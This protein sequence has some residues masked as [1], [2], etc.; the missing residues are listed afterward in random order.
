MVIRRSGY[1]VAGTS[2]SG[3]QVMRKD[4][5]KMINEQWPI[6]SLTYCQFCV[7]N[8]AICID[9]FLMS[10]FYDILHPDFLVL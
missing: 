1:Q 9:F 6:N 5:C 8:F 2:I 3:H 10:W 4:H 7:A